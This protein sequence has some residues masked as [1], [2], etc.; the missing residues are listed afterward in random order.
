MW[1]VQG[2]D[3]EN[4]IMEVKMYI[5]SRIESINNEGTN[6][7]HISNLMREIET[8]YSYVDHIRFVKINNYDTDVQSLVLVFPTLED[9]DK[10]TRRSYVPELITC[11]LNDIHIN[12]SSNI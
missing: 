7:L 9:M 8:N 5:K 2:T 6:I 1:F 10:D 12:G 3:L 4:A 11:D